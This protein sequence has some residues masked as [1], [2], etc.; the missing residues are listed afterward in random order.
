VSVSYSDIGGGWAG[1]GNINSD[2]LFVNAAGGDYHLQATSLCFNAGNNSL[3]PVGVT[4][5]MD[6]NPRI[7][8]RTV[9]MGAF[10]Y[11]VP[12][13]P[14]ITLQPDSQTVVE[15]DTASFTAAA[16]GTPA[17]TV[18]W[19][20]SSNSGASFSDISGARRTA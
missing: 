20:V 11:Q 18:Q 9:D 5:D 2:P 6:G 8:N 17:P 4:L 1:T 13:A 15:G 14:A 7:N 16:N 3:V 10:E 19:Q 12:G